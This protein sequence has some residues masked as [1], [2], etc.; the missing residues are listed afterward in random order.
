MKLVLK[1]L[2]CCLH[3]KID[4]IIIRSV[5]Y[6]SDTI[7][8]IMTC[9]STLA[10]LPKF[11]WKQIAFY[12]YPQDITKIRHIADFITTFNNDYCKQ[13]LLN[14]P[15]AI[16]AIITKSVNDQPE[17]TTMD[18]S[19]FWD[20]A[21][22]HH[23][24]FNYISNLF[25]FIGKK[26]FRRF[27]YITAFIKAGIHD[28]GINA[29][30]AY[31]MWNKY[32][33]FNKKCNMTISGPTSEQTIISSSWI[34]GWSFCIPLYFSFENII[35]DAD[36]TFVGN[37]DIFN[38]RVYTTASL[39]L[40][41]CTFNRRVSLDLLQYIN[42]S[43][44]KFSGAI[45]LSTINNVIISNCEF[46]NQCDMNL[47]KIQ[48][49]VVSKCEFNNQFRL[50]TIKNSMVSQCVFNPGS[51]VGIH[52]TSI[53]FN[54]NTAQ[55]YIF[56]IENVDNNTIIMHCN[57]I[58]NCDAFISFYQYSHKIG[59]TQFIIK[60]NHLTNIPTRRN[61]IGCPGM[62]IICMSKRVNR[63]IRK[64]CVFDMDNSN[65]LTNCGFSTSDINTKN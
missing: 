1:I 22:A 13:Y 43:S 41:N 12:L 40:T 44:Y 7:S 3:K 20:H 65:I 2:R 52:N 21:L 18:D 26:K 32:N 45:T 28:S 63:S 64:R 38:N 30:K 48:N 4:L 36:C 55:Q 9:I 14:T 50:D 34:M 8:T 16:I 57:T 33:F 31:D 27:A 61:C 54:N 11:L 51:L 6:D 46:S 59:T 62:E 29:V 56:M 15:E 47:T 37:K 42:I 35:F 17:I 19:K 25:E 24:K 23:Y 53:D 39:R 60:N 58:S 10:I 49:T 5:F